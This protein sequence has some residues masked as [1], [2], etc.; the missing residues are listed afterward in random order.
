MGTHRHEHKCADNFRL[1]ILIRMVYRIVMRRKPAKFMTR[2]GLS[3][4]CLFL[5]QMIISTAGAAGLLPCDCGPSRAHHQDLH[6]NNGSIDSDSLVENHTEDTNQSSDQNHCSCFCHQVGLS[7]FLLAQIEP[8]PPSFTKSA[9]YLLE[10]QAAESLARS[11]DLPP[12][13]V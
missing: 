9:L 3:L 1:T 7:G 2:A 13:L 6:Q 10:E 8:V 11:I 4:L 12:Q 5:V